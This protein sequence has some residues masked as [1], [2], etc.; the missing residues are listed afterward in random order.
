MK[1]LILAAG[2][3]SRLRPLT[4]HIPKCLV[5][6]KNKAILDYTLESFNHHGIVDVTVVGGYCLDVL[7]AHCESLKSNINLLVNEKFESTNMV[8]SFFAA[9]SIFDDDLILSYGDIVFHPTVLSSLIKKN[10]PFVIVIDKR[11]KD[12]WEKRMSDPLMDAETLK[13]DA[14]DFIIELGKKPKSFE[15]IQGQYIG[16][17]KFSKEMLQIAKQ[18]YDN[19]DRNALYDGKP[20]SQMYMTTFLQL[21]INKGYKAKANLIYGGWIEVDEPSDLSIEMVGDNI[22]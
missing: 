11:W 3:G 1:G 4:D 5:Q 21:L 9:R 18:F 15:E 14:Q 20:F 19:L 7:V 16:L 8:E 17:I 6:Y 10:D 12:L 13:L 2:Q 22:L